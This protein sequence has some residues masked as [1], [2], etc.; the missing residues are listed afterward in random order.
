MAKVG[1]PRASKCT[2]VGVCGMRLGLE[3]RG[4]LRRIG[5]IDSRFTPGGTPFSGRQEL[6]ERAD[7]RVARRIDDE[8]GVMSVMARRDPRIKDG[9]LPAVIGP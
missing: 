2:V 8:N 4:L 6:E 5:T 9:F 7:I 3:R 1:R